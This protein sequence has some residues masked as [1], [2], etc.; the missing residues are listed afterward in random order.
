M[1]EG[2]APAATA[3]C[4]PSGSGADAEVP[5]EGARASSRRE[6]RGPARAVPVPDEVFP[7]LAGTG[8]AMDVAILLA[9]AIIAG[10]R[11]A[12]PAA[13]APAAIRQRRGRRPAHGPGWHVRRAGASRPLRLACL[14]PGSDV[15]TIHCGANFVTCPPGVEQGHPRCHATGTCAAPWPMARGPWRRPRC[16]V[17]SWPLRRKCRTRKV[18]AREKPRERA[19]RHTRPQSQ[20][21]YGPCRRRGPLAL[22]S[23]CKA[24]NEN[25]EQLRQGKRLHSQF[26]RGENFWRRAVL[27]AHLQFVWIHRLWAEA[28]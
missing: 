2:A 19:A 5:S 13:S 1:P 11:C 24:R 25:A 16:K 18:T 7:A 9:P 14:P 10:L 8:R 26:A 6:L 4:Q 3:W 22:T 17:T 21:M 20:Q 28:L 27:C 15:E 23:R 12:P